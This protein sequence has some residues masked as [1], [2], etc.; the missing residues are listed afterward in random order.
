MYI[1]ILKSVWMH[2]FGEDTEEG[3]W[4][5][6]NYKRHILQNDTTASTANDI[7]LAINL[8]L[9]DFV[10]LLKQVKKWKE[11]KSFHLFLSQN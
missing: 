1:Y 7:H 8:I 10:I 3:G 4:Q 2:P 9:I 6:T 11:V 5:W